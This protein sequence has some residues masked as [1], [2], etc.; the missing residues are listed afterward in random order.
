M[1][2]EEMIKRMEDLRLGREISLK[3]ND[4]LLEEIKQL[5]ATI[6]KIETITEK[7]FE[8]AI[9]RWHDSDVDLRVFEYLGI[10]EDEYKE[11]FERSCGK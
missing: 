2:D 1:T 3:I 8:E 11:W 9:G 7:V 10:T 6:S 4:E 5:K